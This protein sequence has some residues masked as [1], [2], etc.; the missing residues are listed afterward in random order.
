[1][2]KI[3]KAKQRRE[4]NEVLISQKSLP[5]PLRKGVISPGRQGQKSSFYCSQTSHHKR[6]EHPFLNEKLRQTM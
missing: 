6:S 4:T 5:G 2:H 3:K 1:M